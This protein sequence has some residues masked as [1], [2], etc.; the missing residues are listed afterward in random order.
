[1]KGTE[2]EAISRSFGKPGLFVLE[3]QVREC[4]LVWS[5]LIWGDLTGMELTG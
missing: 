1:M 2:E 5:H 3:V 4:T